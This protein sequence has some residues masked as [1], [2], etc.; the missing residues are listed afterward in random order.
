MGVPVIGCSCPVCRSDNPKNK[1]TRPGALLSVAGRTLLIDAG[2]DFRDQALCHRIDRLDGVILTHAHHD[3]TAGIDDLRIYY[4]LSGEA[5]P[6]LMSTETFDD[7]E[8]RYSYIFHKRKNPDQL[9]SKIDLHLLKDERGEAAFSDIP[10]RYFTYVQAGMPV[11]GIRV[12]DF[13]YVSDIKEYPETIFE[14][15]QGVKTL[16]VSALR[17]PSSPLHFSVDE[18]VA[19]SKKVGANAT[20]LTHLSHELDHEKVNAYL[21]SNIRL[22]YDGLQI[23]I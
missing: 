14:D 7:L 1:R 15:L 6:C 17:F 8:K 13:A 5:V 9:T 18:A 23:A 16:V 10:I 12:G 20:W 19:F 3:H 21:P 22:A 4:M 2:P 11:T